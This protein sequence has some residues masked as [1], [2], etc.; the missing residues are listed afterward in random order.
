[1]CTIFSL[2]NG[3][4]ITNW[5]NPTTVGSLYNDIDGQV[6][7][8]PPFGRHDFMS[9]DHLEAGSFAQGSECFLLTSFEGKVNQHTTW[10]IQMTAL[11]A[12]VFIGFEGKMNSHII[13]QTNSDMYL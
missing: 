10:F 1:M 4:P 12:F 6:Y 7:E 8:G 2:V 9:V 5:D 13:I 3:Q 11:T